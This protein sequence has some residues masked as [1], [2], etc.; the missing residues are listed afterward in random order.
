MVERDIA[1]SELNISDEIFLTGT[2][3]E[4]TPV[5]EIDSKRIGNG[6]PG[7]ITTKM[8]QEYTDI[9]MNKNDDY[10][11]WLTEVY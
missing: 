2:A 7:D 9:V 10:E 3:A 11:H 6:K 5:I 8:M 4:I 1:R